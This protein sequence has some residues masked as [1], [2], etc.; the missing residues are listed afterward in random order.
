[1]KAITICG[2]KLQEFLT[3]LS[4]PNDTSLTYE[5]A[6]S[7]AKQITPLVN[8]LKSIA[9]HSQDSQVQQVNFFFFFFSFINFLNF[10]KKLILIEFTSCHVRFIRKF[11]VFIYISKRTC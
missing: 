4:H 5:S 7:T 10:F 3:D 9:S 8:I 1:M 11:F 6:F 2:S